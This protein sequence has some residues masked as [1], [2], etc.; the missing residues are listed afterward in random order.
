MGSRVQ[1]GHHPRWRPRCAACRP[2][3]S[4]WLAIVTLA[5]GA[6]VRPAVAEPAAA[7][8]AVGPEAWLDALT[9]PVIQTRIDAGDV[10]RTGSPPPTCAAS[11][12][13]T[14]T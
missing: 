1:I 5:G 11:A 6:A 12:R 3:L 10:E 9:I 4:R 2:S 14:T 8:T 13:S 7:A